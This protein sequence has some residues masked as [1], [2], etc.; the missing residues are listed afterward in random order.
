M[1]RGI[2][3]RMGQSD[4]HGV[5]IQLNVVPVDMRCMTCC[6]MWSS[7][8]REE[9]LNERRDEEVWWRGEEIAKEK[10]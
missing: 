9:S 8:L 6:T 2:P 1:E 5:H 7:S 3:A 10:A 4:R